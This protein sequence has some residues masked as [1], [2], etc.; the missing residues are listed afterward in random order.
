[1]SQS[2]GRRLVPEPRLNDDPVCYLFKERKEM[3]YITTYNPRGY[4]W[5]YGGLTTTSVI[6]QGPWTV[7]VA[8]GTLHPFTGLTHDREAQLEER[9]ETLTTRLIDLESEFETYRL[10]HPRPENP[11]EAVPQVPTVADLHSL[12]RSEAPWGS[13][14]SPSSRNASPLSVLLEQKVPE[15][16]E[17]LEVPVV[18]VTATGVTIENAAEEDDDHILIPSLTNIDKVK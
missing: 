3:N 11:S 7:C 4:T 6:N 1:M 14:N 18:L 8:S 10:A 12:P 15:A 13:A 17:V 9:L 2:R 16:K 5:N